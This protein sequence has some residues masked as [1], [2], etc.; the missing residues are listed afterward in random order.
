MTL[1]AA[2]FLAAS[3]TSGLLLTNLEI[4]QHRISTLASAFPPTSSR[5]DVANKIPSITLSFESG[6][7]VPLGGSTLQLIFLLQHL[8]SVQN[9][10][11][12]LAPQTFHNLI[13]AFIPFLGEHVA[14]LGNNLVHQVIRSFVEKARFRRLR[15]HPCVKRLL[16]RSEVSSRVIE[17]GEELVVPNLNI[18]LLIHRITL[19]VSYRTYPGNP[20][21]RIRSPYANQP[22]HPVS[23]PTPP[24]SPIPRPAV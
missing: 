8:V 18:N 15:R 14:D 13:R 2:A 10:S 7:S 12:R 11:I 19:S 23:V 4:S 1:D 5:N 22:L 3:L 17:R 16:H 20:S 21:V 6:A 9:E 24:V